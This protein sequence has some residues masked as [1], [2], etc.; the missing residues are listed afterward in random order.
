[1]EVTE[2]D[3]Y[4]DLELTSPCEKFEGPQSKHYLGDLVPR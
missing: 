3:S 4:Y 1:M 2:R